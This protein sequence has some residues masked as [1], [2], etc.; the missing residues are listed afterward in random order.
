MFLLLETCRN[1]LFVD[2]NVSET[3]MLQSRAMISATKQR[4]RLIFMKFRT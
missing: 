3:F 2:K 1:P 4:N